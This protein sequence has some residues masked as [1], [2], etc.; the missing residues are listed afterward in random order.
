VT[1]VGTEQKNPPAPT[2]R[3]RRA[4]AALLAVAASALAWVVAS[5]LGVSFDVTSPAVGTIHIG[6][7]LTI[8][9]A[10]PLAL[11]AWGALALLER[12][13]AHPRRVWAVLSSAV[14]VLSLIP[15]PFL[16][17]AVT[18][19][20]ALGWMHIVTGVVL[21]FML[22]RTARARR[23]DPRASAAV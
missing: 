1:T 18:T 2:L 3:R 16:D 4:A 14:L 15:L 20:V 7:L 17:A 23:E 22:G 10:L 8:V 13:T 9:S 12:F 19:K 21:I 6:M 5:L 11:A